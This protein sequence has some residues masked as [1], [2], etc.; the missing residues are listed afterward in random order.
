MTR[1]VVSSEFE[2]FDMTGESEREALLNAL[3]RLGYTVKVMGGVN[4]ISNAVRDQERLRLSQIL[5]RTGGV[6]TDSDISWLNHIIDKAAFNHDAYISKLLH[7]SFVF[8]VAYNMCSKQGARHWQQVG[9]DSA[10]NITYTLPL[11]MYDEHFNRVNYRLVITK[12]GYQYD[13]Q[14]TSA[15]Q[16][17]TENYQFVWDSGR[18]SNNK[19]SD[20]EEGFAKLE[21]LLRVS[22]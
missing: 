17:S 20:V 11:A 4:H 15:S 13:I 19:L 3:D 18:I 5:E 8:S 2:T 1:I 22:G 10:V 14:I 7:Y 21:T 12:R 6:F 16:I 9:A